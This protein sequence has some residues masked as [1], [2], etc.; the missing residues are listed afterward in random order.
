[1]NNRLLLAQSRRAIALHISQSLQ[2]FTVQ[3]RPLISDGFGGLCEDITGTP[4]PVV[5]AGRLIKE[6]RIVSALHEM[7][8]AG[9]DSASMYMLCPWDSIIR[10]GDQFIG[11]RVGLV[12]PLVK[13]G[14]IQ[15]LE[16]S[17]YPA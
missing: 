15:A 16:A 8:G 7:S 4:A 5:I 2:S 1:V 9:L 12:T 17:L 13:F 6:S 10:E 14:G 3:R 11:Y